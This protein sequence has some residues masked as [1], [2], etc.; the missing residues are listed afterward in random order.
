MGGSIL[1][2]LREVPELEGKKDGHKCRIEVTV[3]LGDDGQPEFS[4]AKY[5]GKSGK[6]SKEE[7]LAMDEKGQADYDQAQLN[8]Q[9]P[10]QD[11]EED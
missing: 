7:Y 9:E 8:A 11:D 6:K 3:E 4:D 1:D 10:D 2:A 5:I